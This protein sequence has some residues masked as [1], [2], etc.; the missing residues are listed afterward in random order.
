MARPDFP[1]STGPNLENLINR[2]NLFGLMMDSHLRWMRQT[3][4]PYL[5]EIHHDLAQQ[6]E[7]VRAQ[8]R[9]L[10]DALQTHRGN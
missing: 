7:A 9:T 4:D 2:Y 6:F 8:Y 5:K 1:P 3:T 10:I